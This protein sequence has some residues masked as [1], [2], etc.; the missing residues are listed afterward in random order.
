MH[1][2]NIHTQDCLRLKQ[3]LQLLGFNENKCDTA[4]PAIIVLPL[5][6]GV[7]GGLFIHSNISITVF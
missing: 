6:R 1:N 5:S 2:P 4:G 7:K 3:S